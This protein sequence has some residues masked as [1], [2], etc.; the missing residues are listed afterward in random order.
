MV[1]LYF[2]NVLAAYQMIPPTRANL[3]QFFGATPY[4]QA[5]ISDGATILILRSDDGSSL[6]SYYTFYKI[7]AIIFAI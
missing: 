2:T 6:W 7:R 5:A 4:D 1:L 3:R